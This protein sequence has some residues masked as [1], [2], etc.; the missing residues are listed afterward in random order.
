MIDLLLLIVLPYVAL[1]VCVAGTIYRIKKNSLSYS[2]LSSQFLESR[3]LM[4]GSLPWHIGISV[5]ILGHLAALVAPQPFQQMLSY[6]PVLMGVESVGIGLSLI[7]LAG[8][9]ILTVRRITSSK[10]QAV[11]SATDLLV[12][13]LLLLQ[14]GLGLGIAMHHRWG[15]LWG[16]GLASPYILSIL[17]FRPD[18]AM[19]QDFP[20][21]LKAHIVGAWLLILLI[22]FSRLIHIFALP[23]HYLSRPPINVVWNNARRKESNE[24]TFVKEEA[25]RH[26]LR[27]GIGVAFG[28]MLLSAGAFDKVFRFFFGPR[29]SKHQETELM[30]AKLERLEATTAQ[31]KLELERQKNDYILIG[32]L[33]ELSPTSGK[34]FIDY[35]MRPA[36]AFKGADG[37]PLL[38]SAKCTHLGCTV[39]NE[40][41]AEGKILCPCHISF[42]DVK[43]GEPNA[44]SPAKAPLPHLSWVIRDKEGEIVLRRNAQGPTIGN[45][46]LPDLK[47]AKVYISKSEGQA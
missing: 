32:T 3:G 16:A 33:D 42:F 36:I 29:L 38:I 19:V 47:E 21:L 6:Y 26:F 13:A 30:E 7:C 37:L 15:A 4:W 17:T 28:V 11:T 44:D 1:A 39:G 9:L 27:G 43:T 35:E 34:Y 12:L 8:I 46:S 18:A 31:R 10:L 2:S 24:E 14:V 22:P 41:N 40:M 23:I 5:I 20:H 45:A 25:R